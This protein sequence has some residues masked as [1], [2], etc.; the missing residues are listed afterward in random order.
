MSLSSIAA[1]CFAFSMAF[2]A[3][4]AE[5]NTLAGAPARLRAAIQSKTDCLKSC[6]ETCVAEKKDDRENK[7]A[8]SQCMKAC[9]TNKCSK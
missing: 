7:A 2:S 5:D 6:F 3:V 4:S 8:I 9:H 1:L